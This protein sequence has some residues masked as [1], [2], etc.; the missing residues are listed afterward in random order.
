MNVDLESALALATS[1]G[2][3]LLVGLERERNPLAKA[4]LRTFA[5]IAMLGCLVTLVS[6]ELGS[7][8]IVAAAMLL[9]GGSITAAYVV[10]PATKSDD[11]GTTTIVAAVLVFA[12]GALI[13][14]GHSLLG[15]AIGVSMTILLYFKPELEGFSRKLTPQ[16]LRSMLRF[17]VLSAVVLPLLPDEPLAESGP[18]SA[19][20]PHNVWLM[21]VIVSG[22][23]L[24]GYVAWRMTLGRHGLLVTGLLGGVAGEARR[25]ATPL[26]RPSCWRTPRCSR[27]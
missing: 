9:V 23:S 5:L 13:A 8:W 6:L 18:F 22:V 11:T 21:I 25:P 19:L 20:S 1:A 24:A 26:S 14:L 4:G 3:G 16:D 27:A 15:V 17:A 10:D 2:V 12:L 7:G